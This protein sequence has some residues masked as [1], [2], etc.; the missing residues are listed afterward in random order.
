MK[1]TSTP[2]TL[3]K[4]RSLSAKWKRKA[5]CTTCEL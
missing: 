1:K 3:L 5:H 2:V 4:A